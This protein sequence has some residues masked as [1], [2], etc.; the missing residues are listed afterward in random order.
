MQEN[1]GIINYNRSDFFKWLAR[2]DSFARGVSIE[3]AA[4]NKRRQTS[5]VVPPGER[6]T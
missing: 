2:A 5:L 6:G 1:D 4:S 3:Q